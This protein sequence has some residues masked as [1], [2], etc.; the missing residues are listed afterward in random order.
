MVSYRLPQAKYF[1]GQRY[2]DSAGFVPGLFLY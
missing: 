2:H 1:P